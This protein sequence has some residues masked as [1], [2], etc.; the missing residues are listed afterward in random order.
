[1]KSKLMLLAAGTVAALSTA[2]AV[3]ITSPMTL[4][5]Q[6]IVGIHDGQ[7]ANS[8]VATETLIAQAILDLALG[9]DNGPYHANN[10]FDYSGVITS[11]GGQNEEPGGGFGDADDT[12]SIPAGWGGAL[13]KYDGPNG[14]YVLFLFGGEASTIPEFPYAFW[15]DEL[16]KYQISHFTLFSGTG[17]LTP[18]PFG[19]P[20]GGPGIAMLGMVL[21][22]LGG[23]KVLAA[24]RALA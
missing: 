17:G 19:V 15:T 24:R 9:E 11:N 1:M 22:G 7:E 10:I 21:L 16:D 18:T 8:N 4:N 5:Q 20:E 23:V 2:S 3:T 13:A 12:V 14:G 6:F